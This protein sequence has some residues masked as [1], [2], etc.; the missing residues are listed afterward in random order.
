ML[1][2]P[3]RSRQLFINLLDNAIKYSAAQ[4]EITV[5]A[6]RVDG[7][8]RY[9]FDNPGEPIPD[10]E[11][12]N[13]FQPFYSVSQKQ[14]EEGSVG[15]GLSIV[16]SIVDDHGGTIRIVSESFILSSMLKFLM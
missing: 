11:L 2:Q 9:T 15:L 8:V 14:K 12:A 1:G 10:D 6:E 5:N 16:K 4:S 13:V 3:D 7:S